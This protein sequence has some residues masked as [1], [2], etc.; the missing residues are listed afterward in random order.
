MKTDLEV[1]QWLD[2]L[3][4]RDETVHIYMDTHRREHGLSSAAF[5]LIALSSAAM[6][7]LVETL[8]NSKER[9]NKVLSDYVQRHIDMPILIID[10]DI[11]PGSISLEPGAIVAVGE[12]PA[13]FRRNIVETE[14]IY[15]RDFLRSFWRR[16]LGRR[17][18]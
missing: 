13:Q 7:G 6:V 3:A 11:F 12:T 2:T 16:L 1:W 18:P 10:R 5:P 9:L 14:D 15:F 17:H 4:T 8:V